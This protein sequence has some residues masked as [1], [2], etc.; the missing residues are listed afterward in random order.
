MRTAPR[1]RS[2]LRSSQ[3][4]TER[5]RPT[6]S[7]TVVVVGLILGLVLGF[8]GRVADHS[9]QVQQD[10]MLLVSDLY[11]Q[12]SP[13]TTVRDRLVK[14]GFA[15]ASLAVVQTADQ[16][17][18][19]PDKVKQQEADQLHQ[20]AEALASGVDRNTVASAPVRAVPTKDTSSLPGVPTVVPSTVNAIVTSPPISSTDTSATPIPA[21]VPTAAAAVAAGAAAPAV[22]IATP[23]SVGNAHTGVVRTPD[24]KP[25]FLRHDTSVKSK[26]VASMP[27]GATVE[28]KA[29]VQ[30]TAVD[31]GDTRW[32]HVVYGG[33]DG[34]VY[35]K[36]VQVGG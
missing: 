19:S 17:S 14:I 9:S 21:G 31:A 5:W 20:F 27:F 12:G 32:Y 33:T 10:Y 35:A 7:V 29:T 3:A 28:I 13:L 36:F 11:F 6:P 24:Q 26:A 22:A 30:G 16:L 34:Y 1:R 2:R 8:R 25:V 4:T 18:A 15:D 23:A